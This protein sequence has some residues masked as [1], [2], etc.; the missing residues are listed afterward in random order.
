[1]NLSK[2][3]EVIMMGDEAYA[4]VNMSNME[5]LNDGVDILRKN[6]GDVDR[7]SVV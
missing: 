5:L 1:M 7:K 4:T 3:L 2:E 6:F